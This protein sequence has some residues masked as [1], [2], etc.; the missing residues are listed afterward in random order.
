MGKLGTDIEEG[1]CSW[2]AVKA[3]ELM[4]IEQTERFKVSNYII[5][6]CN[7]DLSIHCYKFIM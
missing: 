3:M 7:A 4:T 1:K 6:M 2:L 5:N